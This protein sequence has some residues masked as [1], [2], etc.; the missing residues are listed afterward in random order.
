MMSQLNL[1][2]IIKVALE[3]PTKMRKVSTA[4]RWL[5]S[6]FPRI[7]VVLLGLGFLVISVGCQSTTDNTNTTASTDIIAPTT[8]SASQTET[9]APSLAPSISSTPVIRETATITTPETTSETITATS[10]P[11][12]PREAAEDRLMTLLTDNQNPNCL[13][14]C[15]WG[16]TPGKT[17]WQDVEPFLASF[18]EIDISSS[19]TAFG[20]TLTL[21]LPESVAVPGAGDYYA[22]YGWDESG[23]IRGIAIDAI[24]ISG[25]DPGTMVALYGIPDEVWLTTID[26]PREGVLP[27]QLII[28]YQQKGISLRYSVNANRVDDTITACFNPGVERQRPGLFPSGPEIYLWEPG[29]TKTIEEISPIPLEEYFP[30]ASKTDLTP[31]TL[32]ERFIDPSEPPC[33][34]TPVGLWR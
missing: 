18:T 22:F 17:K 6:K 33:I 1:K 27:V 32:Y 4:F 2:R 29:Q 3:H 7:C 19:E 12:L 13:L 9:V 16:A 28:V 26:E 15:W 10:W 30:L 31:K 5:S 25:Y 23:L 8:Q 14:P 34:D 11:T 24:N 21:P 20:A